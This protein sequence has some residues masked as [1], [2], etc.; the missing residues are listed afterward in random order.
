[1]DANGNGIPDFLE[2]LQKVMTAFTSSV[3]YDGKIYNNL[4]Q[5]PAEVREKVQDAFAKLNQMGILGPNVT[6][7]EPSKSPAFDFAFK[8]SAPLIPREPAV[9]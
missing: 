2:G 3:N 9:L 7:K 4:H 8:P 5:L 1:M 6:A